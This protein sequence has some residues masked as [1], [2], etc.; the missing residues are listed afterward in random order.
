MST[1]KD[2]AALTAVKYLK[3]YER[4]SQA[5]AAGLK[6][7]T[8]SFEILY[9]AMPHAQKKIADKVFQDADHRG[10]AERGWF[11]LRWNQYYDRKVHAHR[12]RCDD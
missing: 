3:T 8:E 7:P 11:F 1:G 2:A 5:H 9:K 4:F 6:S 12:H 10:T